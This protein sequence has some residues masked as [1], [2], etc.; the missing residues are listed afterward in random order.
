MSSDSHSTITYTSMSSYEVIVNGYFRMPMD[1]LDPYAQLVME[2]PPSPD[3]IP[4]PEAPP[5]PDYIPGPEYLEYLPPADDVLP[6]EEQP[7]PAAVSPTAESPGYITDS[8]PEMEPDEE[9][10]DDEKSEGSS[11]DYPT[12]RGDD[13]T[14]DDGDDLLEDDADDEDGEESSDSKEEEEEHLAPNVPSP[15]LHSSIS[16][17]EDSDQTEPSEEGET[18]ATPPPSTYRIAARISVRPHIPMPFRSESEVERLL[19][20][21]TPSLSPVSPTSYPL[22][23]FLMPLPIF[24]SLPPPPIILPRTRASMVLMRSA[25][26]SIFILAPRSR[27][28]PIGTPLLLP[29]PLPTISFSLTLFLTSTSGSES[30]PEMNMPLRKRTRFTTPTGGYEVGESSVAAT[31][32]QIRP[33]LTIDDNRRAKDIL[34]GRL[35]RE[36][37]LQGQRIN[38]EDRL[39]RHIQHEHTQRDATPDDGDSCS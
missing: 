22:P 27:T 26:P 5:S 28:P 24:T 1:P 16:A 35:R 6:A 33:A 38:D 39:M 23:P 29:I 7:L 3:Y 8:E 21:P 20:I 25:T 12:S 36:S 13:D 17:S 19:A 4:G 10:G 14:D 37:T 30:I 11:I 34:I 31:A 32:R 2:E 18:A 9:D 15:A